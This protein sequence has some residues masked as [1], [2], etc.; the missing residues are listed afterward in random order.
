MCDVPM[1]GVCVSALTV[2]SREDRWCVIQCVVGA[3]CSQYTVMIQCVVCA[4]CS[5][6]SHDPMCSVC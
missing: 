3:E 1:C 4:E 6:Y 5:V 2:Y